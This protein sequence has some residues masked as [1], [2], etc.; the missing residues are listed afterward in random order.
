ML[1]KKTIIGVGIVVII[2]VAIFVGWKLAGALL[3]GGG[4]E[5]LREKRKEAKEKSEKEAQETEDLRAEN[6]IIYL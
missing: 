5:V 2:L 1:N 6:L 4:A 3:V